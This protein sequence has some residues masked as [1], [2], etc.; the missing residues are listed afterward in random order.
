MP[1]YLILFIGEY[2][3]Y[4]QFFLA[5]IFCFIGNNTRLWLNIIFTTGVSWLTGWLIKSFFY[6]PRPFI[7]S[8]TAA[9]VNFHL[10]GSFP[11]NHAV[12]AWS[13]AWSIYWF[14]PKSGTIL[15]IGAILI[16]LGRIFGGVHSPL[17]VAAGFLIAL[18]LSLI[19]HRLTAITPNARL[20]KWP[21]H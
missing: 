1:D 7:L 13:L 18:F 14:Y 12:V 3:I 17:D 20:L 21:F 6:L 16:S 9:I 11:S 10:D 8:K 15:I 19:I 2:L 4:F 5:F